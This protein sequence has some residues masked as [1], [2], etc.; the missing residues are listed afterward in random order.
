[1][2]GKKSWEFDRAGGK[3]V[4]L[5]GVLQAAADLPVFR[6]EPGAAFGEGLPVPEPYDLDAS[7]RRYLL[8]D[9]VYQLLPK[10]S[11]ELKP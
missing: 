10:E 2:P 1:L 5:T 7:R 4:L 3:T 11:E 6:Y 8:K 9:M